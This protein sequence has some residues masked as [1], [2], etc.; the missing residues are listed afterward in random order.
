MSC[1]T[2]PLKVT[3]TYTHNG[4]FWHVRAPNYDAYHEKECVRFQNHAGEQVVHTPIEGREYVGMVERPGVFSAASCQFT[5]PYFSYTFEDRGSPPELSPLDQNQQITKNA[6]WFTSHVSA[7]IFPS[8]KHSV[9]SVKP[10]VCR[11]RTV[12]DDHRSGQWAR[13]AVINASPMHGW[14]RPTFNQQPA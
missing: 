9:C 1:P 2:V 13:P 14:E 7:S 11:L 4:S 12:W 8:L 5:N 10:H 3:M 6:R